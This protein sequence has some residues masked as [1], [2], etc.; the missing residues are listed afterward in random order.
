MIA[1]KNDALGAP[2]T[3]AEANKQIEEAAYYCYLKRQRYAQEGD[4][5]TDWRE[6][7]CEVR[8]S[9]AKSFN[10]ILSLASVLKKIVKK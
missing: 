4:N 5:L 1:L 2:P 7:E 9:K 10:P 3:G 6:A 8:K